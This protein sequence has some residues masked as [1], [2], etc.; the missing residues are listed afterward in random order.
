MQPIRYTVTGTGT[1][2]LINLDYNANPFNVGVACVVGGS[3]T[4]TFSVQ[5]TYADIT[6]SSFATATATWFTA[7]AFSSKTANTDGA[8]TTPCTAMQLRVTGA[9]DPT[10]AVSIIVIQANESP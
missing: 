4:A 1:S 5:H 8:Y 2:P 7:S 9:T 3:G 6:A 10:S